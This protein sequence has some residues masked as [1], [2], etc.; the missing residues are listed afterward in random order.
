M[1]A[2]PIFVLSVIFSA[3]ISAQTDIK[4]GL[5]VGAG[6]TSL[7]HNILYVHILNAETGLPYKRVMEYK[8]PDVNIG[9]KLRLSPSLKHY[10]VDVDATVGLKRFK[11]SLEPWYYYFSNVENSDFV[12]LQPADNYK[13]FQFAI[14]LSW[15][16]KF[17]DKWYA[18]IGFSPTLNMIKGI[19]NNSLITGYAF[20]LPPMI[21]VGY[22]FKYVDLSFSYSYGLLNVAD[23]GKMQYLKELKMRGWQ[24]QCFVPF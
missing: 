7:E 22:D 8:N 24:I 19:N 9:Y 18:G 16:Y 14:T 5:I 1:K 2:L 23:S 10:F 17:I 15:N 21:K 11:H 12:S 6:S 13:Y 20:D 4:H 3:A